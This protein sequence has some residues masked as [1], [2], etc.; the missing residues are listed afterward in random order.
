MH[1]VAEEE[2]DHR[3]ARLREAYDP[4]RFARDAGEV[5]EQLRAHLER[6][7]AR[8]RPVWPD[9]TPDTL[10]DRWPDPE[11]T[12][13]TS[14]GALVA[15]LLAQSTCQ[16]H[17]GFVGQQLSVPPPQAGPVA[18]VSA[19][20]NNS[21]AI[22][23]GAPAAV[24]L[25]RRVVD[26]LVRKAGYG[27]GADGTLTSG[28]T[29]GALTALLAM[30]QARLGADTWNAGLARSERY[31]IFVSGEAHYCNQRACAVL[32]LGADAAVSVPTD[33]R[34]KLDLRSLP[35]IHRHTLNE[36]R[37]PIAL[38]ANSGSTST[39]SHD[40]LPALAVFC[41]EHG[42]WLHVDAAHGGGALLSARYAGRLAG[43][44]QADSL[45]WDAHKMMLVPSLC[46]AVLF[47]DGR[48]LDAAFR[49][50]ASYLLSDDAPW[51][52]PAARNFETTKP[53]AVFPLYVALRTLGVQFFAQAL[54]YAYDLAQAF[55]AELERRAEFELLVRPESNIVCFR[56]RAD[57]VDIDAL[58][59]RLRDAVN[60]G[61]RFFIQRTSHSGAVWLR[62]VLMNPATRLSDLRT[63]LDELA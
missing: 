32:G 18:M 10:L 55:A 41:R 7:A 11:D 57:P 35:D 2:L 25:E 46:T 33:A 30:R 50:E 43:I 54:D 61:G 31:A 36:G 26:W 40:D 34:F 20:L 28:G 51:Y 17:P 45:V 9:T 12:A 56:R 59:N 8:A 38:I 63:L 29:L 16:H 13:G 52:Q 21:V 24:A 19:I 48:H 60:R 47:R 4:D 5:T 42:L 27:P 14:V 6:S 23:E 44:D 49:Q 1:V 3:S 58:Q 62:V 15:D 37:R 22:F 39:G 53:T